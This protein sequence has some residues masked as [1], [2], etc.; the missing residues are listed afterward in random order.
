VAV[1]YVVFVRTAWS[2]GLDDAAF[3]GRSVVP[4]EQTAETDRLLQS[5]TRSSLAL[6]GGALVLTAVGRGRIRLAVVVAAALGGSLLTSELLRTRSGDPSW[7]ARSASSTTASPAVGLVRR[8]RCRV[9]RVA[10][11][12][13][14]DT[15]G[16]QRR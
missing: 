16:R 10:Q 6:L 1:L 13:Y 3:D 4:P 7:T 14:A 15:A 5:I 9:D 8:G 11:T 12:G 2:Q